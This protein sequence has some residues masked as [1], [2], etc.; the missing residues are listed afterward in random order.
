V[1]FPNSKPLDSAPRLGRSDRIYRL[2]RLVRLS[3]AIKSRVF[4]RLPVRSCGPE[5]RRGMEKARIG[6]IVSIR[7]DQLVFNVVVSD[8]WF[9]DSVIIQ[10][11]E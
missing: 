4:T 10:N 9:M 3:E 6:S 7:R 5:M 2:F 8:L 1:N 11:N